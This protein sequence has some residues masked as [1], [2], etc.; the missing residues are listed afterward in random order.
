LAQ[1]GQAGEKLAFSDRLCVAIIRALLSHA[2]L[3]LLA[4][5]V[6]HHH[7]HRHCHCHHSSSLSSVSASRHQCGG[8]WVT[9]P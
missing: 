8:E 1:V 7:H 2:D 6:W 4:N 5:Q 9:T 3:L